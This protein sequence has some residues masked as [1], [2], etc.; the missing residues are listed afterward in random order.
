MLI[1]FSFVEIINHYIETQD[2]K[3][4]EN[5]N[6][7]FEELEELSV[8]RKM[9]NFYDFAFSESEY[10]DAL[11][12]VLLAEPFESPNEMANMLFANLSR[13]T[14][15]ELINQKV[16]VF[17]HYDFDK[18]NNHLENS[19]PGKCD[20]EMQIYLVYDGIN[21]GS[22]IGD[23][24]M[25]INFML[26]PSNP[27]FLDAMES[28]LLH[29]AHHLGMIELYTKSGLYQS[30]AIE[31]NVVQRL[32]IAIV[33]EGI[34]TYL[35]NQNGSLGDL[36]VDSHGLEYANL[37]R[38]SENIKAHEIRKMIKQLNLDLNRI[39]EAKQYADQAKYLETYCC[40]FEGGQPLD[41]AIGV[42]ICK[43]IDEQLGREQMI[44]LL[45]DPRSFIQAYNELVEE[46]HQIN[47]NLDM[48][49]EKVVHYEPK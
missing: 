13:I 2:Q 34:A 33:T 20:S 3:S 17:R 12:A 7:M 28:I 26:W 47:L 10:K 31:K 49:N 29:E 39:R 19:L 35:F 8:Y 21:G 41:K 36:I 14:N 37:Y 43:T 23:H 42:Y 45:T 4:S 44:A 27:K 25:M 40:N 11:K 32:I 38:E 16:E 30:D 22:I 15:S 1:D 18:L 48:T 5:F 24:Q 9:I 46:D 6:A